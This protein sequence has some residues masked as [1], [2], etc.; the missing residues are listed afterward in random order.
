MKNVIFSLP[1]F[2]LCFA[3]LIAFFGQQ[4]MSY[5]MQGSTL[6]GS[7][8]FWYANNP[9]LSEL[10]QF[11]YLVLNLHI[12]M[13]LLGSFYTRRIR[14]YLLIYRLVSLMVINRICCLKA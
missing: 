13:R 5:A 4:S 10:A 1:I 9:P 12:L 11:D 3:V 8:G 2:R 7:V 6:K 14:S